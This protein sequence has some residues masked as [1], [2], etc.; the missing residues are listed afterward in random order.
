MVLV[1]ETFSVPLSK[2]RIA[3]QNIRPGDIRKDDDWEEFKD[4][5]SKGVL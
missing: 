4:S 5:V 1:T 2:L 3:E